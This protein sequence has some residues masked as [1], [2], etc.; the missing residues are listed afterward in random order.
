[1]DDKVDFIHSGSG[2]P[3]KTIYSKQARILTFGDFGVDINGGRDDYAAVLNCITAARESRLL[4]KLPG[5]GYLRVFP[6][7]EAE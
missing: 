5:C 7:L 4:I 6:R 3:V 1:M 2:T